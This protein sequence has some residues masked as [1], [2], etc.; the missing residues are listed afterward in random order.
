MAEVVHH[1]AFLRHRQA[2]AAVV[3]GDGDAEQAHLLHVRDDIGG[4]VVGLFQRV[5]GGLQAFVD[6]ALHRGAQQGKGF[7]VKGHGDSPGQ[8]VRLSGRHGT[9]AVRFDNPLQIE[10][11]RQ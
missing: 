7:L 10:Q 2:D 5:L 1:I 11:K 3:F 4:D 8:A 9:P 6:E